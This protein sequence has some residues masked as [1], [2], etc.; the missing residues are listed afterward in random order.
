[1]ARLG[2]AEQALKRALELNP[3]LSPAENVLA[4][5]EVD[6]GRT[7]ES[8]VRLL[9]RAKDRPANPD[10]YAGLTHA[11]RYSGLLTASIAAT[12]Q[13][14]QLDPRIRT[15]GA[16]THFMLGDYER[17]LEFQPEG[18]PYMRNLALV[19]LGRPDEAMA[20]LQT[21]RVDSRN[22]LS[23]YVA[24]L[25]HTILNER[26]QAATELRRLSDI[27]DP[28]GRFYMARG[29]AYVGEHGEALALLSSAVDGGF[30]CLPALTRDPWLDPLR[31]M[32]EFGALIRRA[33]TRH[34]QALIAFLNAEGDRILGVAHPA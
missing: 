26:E 1:M 27:P 7:E 17:V 32:P 31:G 15:S 13:A 24:A 33:E 2:M 18:I 8:M 28:E 34:R 9:K 14:R 29:L 19:M 23:F 30:F 21:V 6:L 16:H 11:C 12:E 3:D 20:E 4:H 5:L 25:R 22:R 10:L